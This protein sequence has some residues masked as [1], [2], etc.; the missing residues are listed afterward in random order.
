MPCKHPRG[1]SNFRELNPRNPAT[2]AQLV[3]AIPVRGRT[4]QHSRQ[5]ESNSHSVSLTPEHCPPMLGTMYTESTQP[6]THT[7]SEH[8]SLRHQKPS[9]SS[10]HPPY[11]SHSDANSTTGAPTTA[12]DKDP[13]NTTLLCA[14]HYTSQDLMGYNRFVCHES[15]KKSPK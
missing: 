13:E 7:S 5:P 11:P 9:K 1:N 10:A 12:G 6:G 8:I 14:R 4:P 3:S 2:L 15:R